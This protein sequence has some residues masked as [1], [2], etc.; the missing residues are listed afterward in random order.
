[1]RPLPLDLRIVADGLIA[2][3][4][5]VSTD[6]DIYDMWRVRLTRGAKAGRRELTAR[7]P[8][9]VARRGDYP[10]GPDAIEV[11]TYLTTAAYLA[12]THEAPGALLPT[13]VSLERLRAF[14]GAQ[15]DH[16]LAAE[17][18]LR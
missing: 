11:M 8:T 10:E 14:L 16:Y 1:M 6:D 5:S 7:I 3:A 18:A 9:L 13:G 2:E 15:Y 12:Q 4:L 17:G